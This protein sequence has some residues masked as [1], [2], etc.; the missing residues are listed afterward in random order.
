MTARKWI[1][2]LVVVV[3]SA[4]ALGFTKPG[5]RVLNVIGIAT[6]DDDDDDDNPNCGPT[7]CNAK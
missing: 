3:V 4:A 5:H 7:A 1:I 6:A 2:T